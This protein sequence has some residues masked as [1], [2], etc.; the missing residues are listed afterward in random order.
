MLYVD[1]KWSWSDKGKF[2][3]YWKHLHKLAREVGLEPLSW[4][5]PHLQLQGVSISDLRAGEYP[6]GGDDSWAENLY[7]EIEGWS[8]GFSPPSPTLSFGR[9]ALAPEDIG[10]VVETPIQNLRNRPRFQVTARTGLRLRGGAGTGFDILTTLRSGQIVTVISESH[11]WC[12]VDLEGD[13]LAD[14]YCY[15]GYLQAIS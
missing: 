15:S 9:P 14:G 12:Q 13:G 4:E 2:K 5:T 7:A 8:I 6:E 1:G 3:Q 10:S 11:G